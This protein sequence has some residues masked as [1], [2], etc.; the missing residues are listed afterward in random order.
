MI[1]CSDFVLVMGHDSVVHIPLVDDLLGDLNVHMPIFPLL[2][3]NFRVA[4]ST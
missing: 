2:D 3:S 1:P 4:Q